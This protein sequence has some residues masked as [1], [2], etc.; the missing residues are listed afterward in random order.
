MR[1]T[2]VA[3]LALTVGVAGSVALGPAC[4]QRQR[5]KIEGQIANAV[6]SDETERELGRQ[7]HQEL[8]KQGVRYVQDP[9]VTRYV[10]G[11]VTRLAKEVKREGA[12]DDLKVFVID[13]PK[14]VNA[15]ATPGGRL[16][17]F[18][19]LLLTAED[20]A[21]VAGVL[22]HE[23]G[24]IVASHPSKRIA[25]AMGFETL[26]SLALGQD[27]GQLQELAA[28]LLGGGVLA[29]HG[30]GE[31]NEADELGLGYLHRAGFDPRGMVR[32]F[33]RIREASGDTPKALVW[34][35]SHPTT[36]SRIDNV[37]ET[38]KSRGWEGGEE[39]VE[40]HAAI[41]AALR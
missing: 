37:R 2:I 17:V 31:E 12:A 16:Y 39:G 33:K 24:H 41:R 13:D 18:T 32:F 3:A 6:V 35:S 5:S 20:E 4:S 1:R 23:I 36:T 21:E 11:I 7:V 19:G 14:T 29:A 38:I 34:L 25:L 22:G 8:E 15:F 26:A 28:S 40:T 9:V 30:R 10:E 27:P